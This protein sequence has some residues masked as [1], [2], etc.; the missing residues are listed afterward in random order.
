MS[1]KKYPHLLNSSLNIYSKLTAHYVYLE[2]IKNKPTCTL[3]I[4]FKERI[5]LTEC[6]ITR[7]IYTLEERTPHSL[8]H[9]ENT[10][11]I[12]MFFCETTEVS[13]LI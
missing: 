10:F 8:K 1:V 7:N 12:Q 3:F 6:L 4:I 9:L 11:R 5:S 2:K 13:H